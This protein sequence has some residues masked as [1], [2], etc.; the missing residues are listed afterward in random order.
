[1]EAGEERKER[2]EKE[3]IRKKGG[4]EVPPLM[5]EA[6]PP[7]PP[8]PPPPPRFP[9][10]TFSS[11]SIHPTPFT[12]NIGIFEGVQEKK[13]LMDYPTRIKKILKKNF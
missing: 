11:I 2:G 12:A 10:K 1:M 13:Y 7:P 9:F 4:E 6:H 5:K 3:K 8:P